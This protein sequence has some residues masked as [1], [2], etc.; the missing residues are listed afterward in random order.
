VLDRKWGYLQPFAPL[1][2]SPNGRML[3]LVRSPQQVQLVDPATGQEY[4]TLTAPDSGTTTWLCFSP[5]NRW[6]AA[7]NSNREVHLW[8]LA[9][10]RQQLL[11][12]GLDW[13]SSRDP[14]PK[15][16]AAAQAV[17]VQVLQ[18]T[19]PRMD[20]RAYWRW[21]GQWHQTW[22]Q[23][24]ES[25]EDFTEALKVLP[26]DAPS[27]QRAELLQMRA[28][29][30]ARLR[31]YDT[32]LADLQKAVELA[33][34]LAVACHDLARLYVTG[35]DKLRDPKKALP[36]ARQ[37]V[38]LTAGDARYLNTLGVVYYRLG[39]YPQAVET[40][41]RS[42]RESKG[43]ADAFN[44]FYLAMCHARRGESPKAKDCYNRAVKWVQE[45]QGKLQ[46]ADVEELT[47]CRAEA[48]AELAKTP[49]P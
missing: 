15:N 34:D 31:A 38:E 43:R 26:A 33:P 3:A 28:L 39:Q 24:T 44:L 48:E 6:L 1:A 20:F 9:T 36:L 4:A 46:R 5:D 13:D 8:D 17:H 22:S 2:F 21:R 23:W 29:G 19:D 49:R 11:D 16:T 7:A 47:A 14:P 30:Y 37:A 42:L 25:V 45:R 35:P 10:V 40:L 32:A 12:R 41:E 18:A 27:R